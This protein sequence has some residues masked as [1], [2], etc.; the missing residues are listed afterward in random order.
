MS[1][2]VSRCT[3]VIDAFMAAEDLQDVE[4]IDLNDRVKRIIQ[5]R[6]G[7]FKE[8]LKESSQELRKRYNIER[9]YLKGQFNNLKLYARW[10]KPYL[11]AAKNLEQKA[12]PTAALV[13]AFN[14]VLF[15][16]T[17]LAETDYNLAEEVDKGDLPK[18]FKKIKTRKY[19]PI[20][21]IE[22]KF[23]S[24]PERANQGYGFR[25]KL[26][27]EFTSY[28][29]N[30]SEL[31]ILRREI[32]KD[33]VEDLLTYSIEPITQSMNDIAKEVEEFIDDKENI[34]EE[35]ISEESQNKNDTNPISALL[36]IFKSSKKD[37]KKM[38]DDF[39]PKDSDVE[40]MARSQ[41]IIK[42]RLECQKFYG[43]YKKVHNMPSF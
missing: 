13:H 40:K 39:V 14:T 2:P 38:N 31:K 24:I 17:L 7:E 22:L 20:M 15:E 32:E 4:K 11:T 10:I 30:D 35:E 3:T 1:V 37:S 34:A 8:W 21:I 18:S 28:A 26:D 41:A 6:L 43:L 29:L 27:V 25:G 12:S 5:Q 19:S 16:L 23:R 36:S 9:N 42:S 33:D